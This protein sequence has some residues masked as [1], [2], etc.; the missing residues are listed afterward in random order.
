[1]AGR[2][3][4]RRA[5][6]IVAEIEDPLPAKTLRWLRMIDEGES[7]DFATLAGFLLAN[8]DWPWPEQLQIIAENRII[9]PADHELI[10]GL[11]EDRAPLTTRGSIRYAE[12]L[13]RIDQVEA[14]NDLIRR[15]WVEGDF[16][17][18][19]EPKFYRKYRHLLT[20]QDHIDRLDNLLWDYRRSSAMRML[21][22]VPDDYRKLARARMRLQ[23]RQNGVDEALKEVPATLSGDP[24]LT[25][26]RMRWRRQK[27][28]NDGVIELL[29]E[30]PDQL[31]HPSRWWFEREMQ[32]R[33]AL[34]SR[35]F[36]LAYHLAS[37]HGQTEGEEFAAAEWLSGWLALRFGRQP[38]TAQR[39]FERLYAGAEAPVIE[40][41]AAYWL[42]RTAAKLGDQA[43]A[44]EWYRRAA[45]TGSPTTASSR[46][47]SSAPPIGRR[48]RRRSPTRGCAPGSRPR[49][50]CASRGC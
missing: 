13:F 4:F 41:Q 18:S 10:R 15:A 22:R 49:S 40:A 20:G 50:W 44:T 29:L 26:D 32:I 42:G 28:L 16:S 43:R 39:H 47:R 36:D 8:P 35:Q 25:F 21:E 31:V 11:F 12:A 30:P 33:R 34:R 48:R 1:M 37:R 3:D 6:L 7:A 24:G 23:R 2:G 38:N 17:A 45:S 9:D 19:E 46:P 14:A 5:L 27:R